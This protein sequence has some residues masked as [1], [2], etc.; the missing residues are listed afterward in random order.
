MWNRGN[1]FAAIDIGTTKI[2]TLVGELSLERNVR[3]LGVG[4]TPSLGITR[5]MVDN[6]QDATAAIVDSVQRAERASGLRILSAYV[7]IAGDHIQAANNRGVVAIAGGQRAIS[8]DDVDRALASARTINDLPAN[9]EVL[10]VLPRYYIVDGQEYVR[11]PVGMYGQRLDVETHIVTCSLSAIQN[12]TKC[13]ETAGVQVER[14]VLASLASAQAVL[15]GEEKRQGVIVA[16]IGGGTTDIAVLINNAVCYTSVLP[17]GGYHLTHDLVVGL[18]SPFTAAEAAKTVHGHAIASLVDPEDQVEVEA[19]GSQ[20]RRV[21]SRRFLCE[22]LQARVEELLEMIM[23][24]VRR[25]GFDERAS[26]GLVLTGGTARLPGIDT[27]A[28]E[29]TGMP[30]RVGL[31]RGLFGLSDNLSNPAYATSVGLLQWAVSDAEAPSHSPADRLS[32][33]LFGWFRRLGGWMRVLL[34]E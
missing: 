11:Y 23:L 8:E 5:G 14:L 9:R 26:A 34:P 1:T 19:F 7:S 30:V 20:K 17:V 4:I 25:A 29:V 12:L 3:V 15:E 2:C 31:P 16:D 32:E 33:S 13:V 24:D 10:H 21:V 6:V 22:I 18:R 28:E 27:L